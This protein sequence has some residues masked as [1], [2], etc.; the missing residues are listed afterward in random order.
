MAQPHPITIGNRRTDAPQPGDVSI[1]RPS[2]LGNPFI[3]GRDGDCTEVIARYRTWLQKRLATGPGNPAHEE[4]R[5]LL[6][7]AQRRPLRLVC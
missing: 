2:P 3:L 5:R 1:G 7:V 4:L 6:A